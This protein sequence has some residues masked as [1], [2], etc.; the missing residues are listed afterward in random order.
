M[1]D[2]KQRVV[3]EA[4]QLYD[5]LQKLRGFLDGGPIDELSTDDHKDLTEQQVAMTQYLD[6]LRRRIDKF[7][8]GN[9]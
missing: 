6:I 1:E 5:R 7:E 4:N 8:T 2:W 3:D 9:E